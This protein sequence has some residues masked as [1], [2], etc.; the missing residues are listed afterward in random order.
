M[1]RVFKNKEVFVPFVCGISITVAGFIILLFISPIAASIMLLCCLVIMGVFLFSQYGEYNKL[2]RLCDD[3]DK[4]LDGDDSISFDS[5]DEGDISL[6]KTEINKMTIRIREQNRAL[7]KEKTFL[8]DSLADI[9]HQLRTPLTSMS[10]I[11]TMLRTKE[12][13]DP[14]RKRY[15]RDL[16]L[17]TEKTEWLIDT[18]LKLSSFEASAITMEKTE[19]NCKELLESATEPLM[20][21]AELKG[22]HIGINAGEVKL[23]ADFRWCCEAVKNIVKNCIEH[24]KVDSK[25]EITAIENPLFVTIAIEGGN[26]RIEEKDFPHIF[27]RFYKSDNVNHQGYGIGLALA[28]KIISAHDGVIKAENTDKG[29]RFTLIFNKE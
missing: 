18:L 20:I 10:I 12:L 28:K 6:L 21:M 3:I 5:Y 26:N 19:F 4:I 24:S 17:L 2:N 11:L 16:S 14:D 23:Y 13:S 8:Q 22:T 9:S 7:A 29:V 1:M 15:I 25:I 27:E